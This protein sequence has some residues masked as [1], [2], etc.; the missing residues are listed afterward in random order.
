MGCQVLTEVC[1]QVAP[2]QEG[3]FLAPIGLMGA[4]DPRSGSA[5]VQTVHAGCAPAHQW[6]KTRLHSLLKESERDD[7]SKR[8]G[9]RRPCHYAQ[10]RAICESPLQGHV[11]GCRVVQRGRTSGAP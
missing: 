9:R 8:P 5:F 10:P 1:R 11:V 4:S 2:R 3:E 6:R 7:L